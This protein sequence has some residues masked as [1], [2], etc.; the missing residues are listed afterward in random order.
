MGKFMDSLKKMFALDDS[1]GEEIKM[2][3]VLYIT[4]HPNDA[5]NSYSMAVGKEFIE[6]YNKTTQMIKLFISIYIKKTYRIL[7]QTFFLDGENF[8]QAKRLIIFQRLRKQKLV[9]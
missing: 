8:N 4:A 6:A 7:M 3:T 1:E 5:S 2:T 9:V